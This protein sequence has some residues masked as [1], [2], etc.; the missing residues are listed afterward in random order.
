LPS[1]HPADQ[2]LFDSAEQSQLLEANLPQLNVEQRAAFDTVMNATQLQHGRTFFMQG[3]AGSGKTLVEN[4][5][6]FAAHSQNI[7]VLCVASSG[8]AA[9]LLPCSRTAHSTLKIPIDL[10]QHSTCSILKSSLLADTLKKVRLLIWD[11]CSMQHRWVFEAV[12]QTLKISE[13]TIHSSE[14]SPVCLV[15]TSHRLYQ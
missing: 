12:D 5:L 15:E 3:C 7:L 13:T 10:R 11:E 8:I 1:T 9:L 14:A 6:W 4:M 2:L